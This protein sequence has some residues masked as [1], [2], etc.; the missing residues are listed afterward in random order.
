MSE[1]PPAILI[2]D[3][4]VLIDYAGADVGVLEIMATSLW[5][6]HV[7]LPI[8]KEVKAL[9]PETAQK[10]GIRICEPTLDELTEAAVRGGALSAPDKL[11]FAIARRRGWACLTN[12]T[13]LRRTCEKTGVRLVWGLEAMLLLHKSGRLL[14]QRA[15]KTAESIRILN[16]RH[17]TQE[18]LDRFLR[19]LDS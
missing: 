16:P 12:D 17:I 9:T 18:I 1:E 15:V 6:L 14:R 2:S 19:Q 11:C 13:S 5:E 10:I 4:D 3:A 7:A 8:L